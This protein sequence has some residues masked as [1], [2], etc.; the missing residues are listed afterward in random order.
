[1]P[2]TTT[3]DEARAGDTLIALSAPQHLPPE[4]PDATKEP[5]PQ[6]ETEQGREAYA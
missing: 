1:M 4:P 3:A 2:R 6:N 5:D